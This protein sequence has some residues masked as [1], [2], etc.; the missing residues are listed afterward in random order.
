MNAAEDFLLLL[1]HAHVVSS[2][3]AIISEVSV[4]SVADLA[5]LI[6]VNYIKF[7]EWNVDVSESQ[8]QQI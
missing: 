6:V 8:I 5:K 4:E 7:P 3:E 2:A 1:L